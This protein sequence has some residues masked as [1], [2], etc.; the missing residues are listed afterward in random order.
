MIK[1]P[2]KHKIRR[3]HADGGK[4]LIDQRIVS[5]IEG[6]GGIVTYSST[7]TGG[8]N[9][10]NY[11]DSLRITQR[12]LVESLCRS[13]FTSFAD[14]Y[15]QRLYIL[16]MECV[17]GYFVSSYLRRLRVWGCKA[18]VLVPASSRR[19]DWEDKAWTGYFVSYSEDESGGIIY[20]P[21]QERR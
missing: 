17:P 21:E 4:E 5:Y 10:F 9:D 13:S 6:A 3:Y 7:D 1:F 19:K 15:A 20:L 16:F 18:Y 12:F 14:S 8:G 11:T 2:G